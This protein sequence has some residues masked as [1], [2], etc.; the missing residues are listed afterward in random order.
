MQ[1]LI[2]AIYIIGDSVED[3]M[4]QFL[5]SETRQPLGQLMA[6]RCSSS[7]ENNHKKHLKEIITKNIQIITKKIQ[8]K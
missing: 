5:N 4:I 7:K 1:N 2:D 3:I 6:D 8:R